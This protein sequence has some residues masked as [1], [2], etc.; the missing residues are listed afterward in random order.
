MLALPKASGILSVSPSP[1][2][3]ERHRFRYTVYIENVTLFKQNIVREALKTSSLWEELPRLPVKCE[4][5][6]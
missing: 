2:N 5:F 1:E 3:G 6:L 4:H